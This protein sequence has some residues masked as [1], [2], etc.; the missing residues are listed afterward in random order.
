MLHGRLKIFYASPVNT[1]VVQ[2]RL[3]DPCWDAGTSDVGVQQ[4]NFIAQA[5]VGNY[6]PIKICMPSFSFLSIPL[7]YSK[8]R[9]SLVQHC[10]NT[11]PKKSIGGWYHNSQIS[12]VE[13]V[14]H[15]ANQ[16]PQ[17]SYF[18]VTFHAISSPILFSR[19]VLGLHINFFCVKWG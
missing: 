15:M 9:I 6:S 5:R 1:G 16:G 8:F 7:S 14:T 4:A 2:R 11:W 10:W 3:A 17:H 18:A 19:P 12:E 13:I